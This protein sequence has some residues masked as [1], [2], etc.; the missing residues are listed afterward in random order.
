M[1]EKPNNTDQ[2]SFLNHLGELRKHILKAVLAVII[3]AVGAFLAKHFI[4]DVILF[5]PS[6]AS[7]F[8]YELLCNITQ[9]FGM[10]D[11]LCFEK[12]NF[13]IQ[14]RT[15]GGQFSAHIWTSIT[16]GF[17]VAFPYVLYEMW[18]FVA[19]GLSP[20]ER[21]HSKGF[22]FSASILFFIGVL[23]GYYVVTPLSLNFLGNYQVSDLVL[24]QF[25][26]SSYIS[27]V[28][29]TVLASGIAFE[30]PIIIF[31]L[32]SI[33]LI[34]PDDLR[35]NRKMS[36]VIIT[37]LSAIITPPDVV[38]LIIVAIPLLIL[39]EASILISSYALKKKKK[40]LNKTENE[41]S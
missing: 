38:S 22:I 25:D 11:S 23:F 41:A 32:T 16:A 19:P 34:T 40:N 27:L 21:K 17:I 31:I 39:Y 7:F 9:S 1:A 5:G 12:M 13:V 36:I 6:K 20:K 28:R 8:T 15:T 33:E 2:M 18:K 10:D 29:S 14:S 24:N 30:L 26:L 4:F 3:L 35:K 37:I